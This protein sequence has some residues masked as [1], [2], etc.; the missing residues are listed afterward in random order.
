MGDDL[1]VPKGLNA[2]GQEAI[3][4]ILETA[5]EVLGRKVVTGGCRAFY[6]PEEWE[7]RGELYGLKSKLIVVHDGGDLGRFFNYSEGDYAAIKRMADALM[8]KKLS[9]EACTGWY[10]AVYRLGG[11]M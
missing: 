7:D 6:S 5:Q 4:I 10:T 9:A 3:Q 2:A 1:R 8:K 11:S